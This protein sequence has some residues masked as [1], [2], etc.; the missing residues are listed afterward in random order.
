[1]ADII[2]I[3]VAK[4]KAEALDIEVESSSFLENPSIQEQYDVLSAKYDALLQRQGKSVN[5]I[6][7]LYRLLT[8]DEDL[9]AIGSISKHSIVTSMD[10]HFK[11]IE[12]TSPSDEI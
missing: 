8:A 6:K 11:E 5:I 10:H 7:T 4:R 3:E 1:M 2:D 9:H 12:T